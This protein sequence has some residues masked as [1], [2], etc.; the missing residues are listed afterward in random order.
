VA[1][2]MT[3]SVAARVRSVAPLTLRIEFSFANDTG[4]K[5]AN[6]RLLRIS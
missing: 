6:R 5:A 3:R 1:E 2:I 4:E